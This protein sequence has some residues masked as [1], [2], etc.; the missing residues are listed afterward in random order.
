V[1]VNKL[2]L[3]PKK[4][5]VMMEGFILSVCELQCGITR[6]LSTVLTV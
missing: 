3:R 1:A 2:P 6:H 5:D 4:G